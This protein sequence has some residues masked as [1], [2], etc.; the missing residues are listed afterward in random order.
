MPRAKLPK[1]RKRSRVV[2]LYLTEAEFKTLSRLAREER[3]ALSPY[4]LGVLEERVLR[5]GDK[6]RKR[7]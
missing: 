4:V 6:S 1:S 7:R 5:E 3:R 2:A